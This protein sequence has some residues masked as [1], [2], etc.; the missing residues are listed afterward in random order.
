MPVLEVRAVQG[1]YPLPPEKSMANSLLLGWPPRV[2]ICQ[3]ATAPVSPH[4][5]PPRAL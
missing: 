5:K 1:V 2:S 3:S 4:N